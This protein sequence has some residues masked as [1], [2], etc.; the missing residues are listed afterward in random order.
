[1]PNWT[2][3][4]VE[5]EF[6]DESQFNKF[7]DKYLR[8]E[9]EKYVV[10]YSLIIPSPNYKDKTV[11]PVNTDT[12]SAYLREKAGFATDEDKEC[13]DE[14]YKPYG[15]EGEQS[16]VR[17]ICQYSDMLQNETGYPDWYTWNIAN[18]GVKWNAV[19]SI[20]SYDKARL[21]VYLEFLSPWSAPVPVMRKIKE[22]FGDAV[23]I[24]HTAIYEDE[25][26]KEVVLLNL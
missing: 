18:W 10:D 3:N 24:M 7:F 15:Q 9:G 1:M 16:T 25:P 22:I 17:E 12:M 4:T 26:E 2:E 8:R 5:I 21:I 14:I 20:V 11:S 19:D 6:S 23:R 13:L